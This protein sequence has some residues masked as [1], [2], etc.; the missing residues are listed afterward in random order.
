MRSTGRWASAASRCP[1]V[2]FSRVSVMVSGGASTGEPSG[3]PLH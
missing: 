3:F 1:G 2:F